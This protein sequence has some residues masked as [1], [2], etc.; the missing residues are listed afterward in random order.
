M[1]DRARIQLADYLQDAEIDR[2]VA[3]NALLRAE[4]QREAGRR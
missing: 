4:L 1:T 2:L 3:E